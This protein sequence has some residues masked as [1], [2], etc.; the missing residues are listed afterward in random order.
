MNGVELLDTIVYYIDEWD[1]ER[2]GA[3]VRIGLTDI[4]KKEED[5]MLEAGPER[6]SFTEAE[7]VAGL[8]LTEDEE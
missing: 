4:D 8:M 2:V 5:I 7:Y 1:N 6:L 3:F